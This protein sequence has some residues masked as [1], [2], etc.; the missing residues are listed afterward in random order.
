V[1]DIEDGAHIS[2]SPGSDAKSRQA[3]E[4]QMNAAL[5]Q[6]QV[7]DEIEEEIRVDDTDERSSAV[8]VIPSV[9]RES[10]GAMQAEAT[11]K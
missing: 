6:P 10:S 11:L 5:H 2:K 1:P 8:A 7:K 3:Y 9:Q 4:A